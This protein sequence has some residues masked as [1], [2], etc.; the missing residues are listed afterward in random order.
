MQ[1]RRIRG[2]IA[3]GAALLMSVA[4]VFASVT[5]DPQT[6][7]GFV[8]KGDVQTVL[9]WNNAQLQD[10]AGSLAFAA[11]STTVT[12]VS[13][14]CTNDRN[15]MTQERARTTTSTVQGVLAAVARVRTQITGFN[16]TGYSG[17]PTT[18]SEK[19]EGPPVNSCPSGPWSLTTPAG[20][21]EVV[22]SS[23][24]LTVNGVPLQ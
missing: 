13:W 23:T 14:V 15:E 7:A 3:A 11:E 20:D 17:D 12:E 8:G 4:P 16:L 5:F 6:G 22:S 18:T 1:N 9:G 2:L 21:P 19:T 24:V 10:N